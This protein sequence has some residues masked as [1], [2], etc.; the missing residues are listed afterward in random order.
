MEEKKKTRVELYKDDIAESKMYHSIEK[1]TENSSQ[2]LKSRKEFLTKL[3][4][5][6]FK[7]DIKDQSKTIKPLQKAKLFDYTLS[8]KLQKIK[9]T[10][11]AN[12]FDIPFRQSISV[13]MDTEDEIT[14]LVS[15]IKDNHTKFKRDID[16]HEIN[17]NKQISELNAKWEEIEKNKEQ[18]EQDE[19]LEI[20]QIHDNIFDKTKGYKMNLTKSGEAQQISLNQKRTKQL[21]YIG[22]ALLLIIIWFMRR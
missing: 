18:D 9:K 12:S 1:Q 20:Q 3:D 10:L 11:T 8:Q 19:V 21:Y 16:Y 4:Q 6:Y 5:E 2:E 7:H 15:D 13:K 22:L 14:K 17:F